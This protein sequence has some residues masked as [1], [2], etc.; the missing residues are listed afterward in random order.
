MSPEPATNHLNNMNKIPVKI[1]SKEQAVTMG[2]DRPGAGRGTPDLI[3]SVV[4]KIGTNEVKEIHVQSI[5]TGKKQALFKD[6]KHFK[7]DKSL[8]E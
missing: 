2:I 8:S 6:G 7:I 4:A 1:I 3:Y 5:K